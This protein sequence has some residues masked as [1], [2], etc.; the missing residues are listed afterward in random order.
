MYLQFLIRKSLKCAAAG[1]GFLRREKRL[2]GLG[3]T[4]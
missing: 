2:G 4:G 1:M 3:F